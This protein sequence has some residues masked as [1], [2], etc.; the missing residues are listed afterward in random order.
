MD[1]ENPEQEKGVLAANHK[2]TELIVGKKK[3]LYLTY[4]TVF[5]KDS[6]KVIALGILTIF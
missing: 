2:W 1:I 3:K 4:G 5:P 6:V